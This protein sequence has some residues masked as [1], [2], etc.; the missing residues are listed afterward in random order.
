[1]DSAFQAVGL[2]FGLFDRMVEKSARKQQYKHE[3]KMKELEIIYNS[4]LRDQYVYEMLLDKF[5]SLK[6][7]NI[8][9]VEQYAKIY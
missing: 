9:L 5:L 7:E 1:M 4:N 2:A 3:Q 6:S 8:Q